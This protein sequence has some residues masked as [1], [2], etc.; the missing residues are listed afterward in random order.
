MVMHVHKHFWAAHST[1]YIVL[2]IIQD[3]S[4][5]SPSILRTLTDQRDGIATKDTQYSDLNQQLVELKE[6]ETKVDKT[7]QEAK[8]SLG[9]VK[10]QINELKC[11]QE[12][13]IEKREKKR[14]SMQWLQRQ[15]A[16]KFGDELAQI[17]HMIK[18]IEETVSELST[19]IDELEEKIDTQNKHAEQMK[20]QLVL[21]AKEKE[22]LETEMDKI[23]QEKMDLESELAE[24][25]RRFESEMQR[26]MY[27]LESSEVCARM[28]LSIYM[29]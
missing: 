7:L 19:Q 2:T 24:D 21:K 16:S 4:V 14:S 26:M 15:K 22:Q 29:C 13:L 17:N 28:C 25:R 12:S 10:V 23:Q 11:E 8:S 5:Q 18:D 1:L 9:S 27:K 3:S 6:R 20:A